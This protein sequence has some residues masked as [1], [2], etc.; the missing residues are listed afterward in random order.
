VDAAAA[1]LRVIVTH[2]VLWVL[3]TSGEAPCGRVGAAAAAIG[4]DIYVFG[5][6]TGTDFGDSSLNDLHIL[7][8]R[9]GD[10]RCY[11]VLG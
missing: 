3:Q 7:D 9:S 6:R 4:S 8:T 11:K 2:P 1:L 5:G 10:D